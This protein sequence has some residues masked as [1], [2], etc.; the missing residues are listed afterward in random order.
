MLL[1][2]ALES[3]IT[4]NN[5]ANIK[6]KVIVELANGPVTPEADPILYKNGIHVIPDF[7]A[8]AGGVTVSYME[9]VQNSQ[10]YFWTEEDV[11]QKLDKMMSEAYHKVL[12]VS[13]KGSVDMRVAAYILAVGR[14][15]EAMKLRG[16]V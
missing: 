9:M 4:G 8:N 6:A 2:A 10:N 1:P 14:V 15:A 7:L 13:E 5:A 12:D 3:V 11:H 16:W